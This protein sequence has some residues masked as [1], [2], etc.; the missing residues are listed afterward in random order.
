SE[1]SPLRLQRYAWEPPTS[2][3]PS[4]QPLQPTYIRM[5][6]TDLDRAVGLECAF[7]AQGSDQ[8]IRQRD[9]ASRKRF[10][11][12]L[13]P[14]LWMGSIGSNPN[15]SPAKPSQHTLRRAPSE[16]ARLAAFA[17][18]PIPSR[19]RPGGPRGPGRARTP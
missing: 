3:Q 1:L 10:Q 12:T 8:K 4:T 7:S 6:C 15:L 11:L 16:H 13:C 17:E 18:T 14:K 9:S 2:C 19:L 5:R